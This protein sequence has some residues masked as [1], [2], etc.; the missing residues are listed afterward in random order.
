MSPKFI[1]TQHKS[2]ENMSCTRLSGI[3]ASNEAMASVYPEL[4]GIR[5]HQPLE[6]SNDQVLSIYFTSSTQLCLLDYQF[7]ICLR[8]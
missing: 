3:Q 5:R 6:A 4:L 8:S 1:K 2:H 7:Q